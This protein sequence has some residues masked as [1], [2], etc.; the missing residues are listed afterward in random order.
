MDAPGS[1]PP[2]FPPAHAD[3][4]RARILDAFRRL[5]TRILVCS[6]AC[7]ADQMALEAAGALGVTRRVILPFAQARFRQTSVVDRGAEWGEP[8]DRTMA[9]LGAANAV[10]T[11]EGSGD[12]TAA[13]ADANLAILDDAQKLARAS[14]GGVI[15]MLVAEAEAAYEGMKDSFAQEAKKRGLPI[16]WIPTKA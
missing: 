15:A 8:F 16:V 2:R 5:D 6:A 11:L 1:A 3:A 4:V 10:M 13:Y 9:E 12:E 7:G 14:G